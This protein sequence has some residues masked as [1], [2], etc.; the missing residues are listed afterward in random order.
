M[1]KKNVFKW[2]HWSGLI[3]GLFLLLM[4][5]TGS[6]LVF[7]E[8]MESS[9]DSPYLAIGNT[10]GT[11]SYDSSYSKVSALYPGWEI[12]LYGKP[13]GNEALVYELRNKEQRKKVFTHPQSG[14]ILR[15]IDDG[16]TQW[17]RRLLLLHYTLF[18]GTTGKVVVFFIG[19]LF[20]IS[21]VTGLIIYRKAI[22]KTILFRSRISVTTKKSFFS[23]FHRVIGVWSVFFNL[24]IVFTGLLLSGQVVLN[25]L[26]T[27]EVKPVVASHAL[28][29][30][31]VMKHVATQ[32]P[33]FEVH[34]VRVRAN[35]KSV[36]LSGRFLH[37]PPWYGHFYSYVIINSTSME[38]EKQQVMA[39]LPAGKKML[40]MAGPLHFGNYGGIPLKI[41]YSLLG[42]T[43]GL[44][45]LTGF[46]L[47]RKRNR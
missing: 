14:N 40:A 30:D 43:P 12:R 32:Y 47:W 22:T 35:S 13:S 1:N 20:L 42:I 2:H 7:S 36:Q 26:K 33:D 11:Y 44:L 21:L 4:S 15:V 31:R 5:L 18:A 39:S 27:A 28:S 46:L 37:D 3:V 23:S 19:I 17:H 29:I 8:E 16:N 9:A 34:L 10:S 45:S 25:A 6:I 24:L 41:L 38:L